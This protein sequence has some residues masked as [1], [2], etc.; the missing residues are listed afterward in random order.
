[1]TM[2]DPTL[3]WVKVDLGQIEQVIIKLAANAREAMPQGG[4]ITIETSSIRGSAISHHP[5]GRIGP[6]KYA[7]LAMSASGWVMDEEMRIHLFEP[8]FRMKEYGKTPGL[9]L[10]MVYGIVTQNG[11]QIVVESQPGLGKTFRIYLILV[12]LH[13]RQADSR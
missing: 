1:T 6:G 7:M 8:F 9:E 3:A 10:S 13:V 4:K 12:E 5:H 2:L 11:G